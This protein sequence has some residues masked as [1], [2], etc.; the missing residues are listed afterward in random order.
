M[1]L[2]LLHRNTLGHLYL[3]LEI[4]FMMQLAVRI[5]R[6]LVFLLKQALGPPFFY[7]ASMGTQL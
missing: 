5:D 2:Q 7:Y 1:K 3:E 4:N 6:E